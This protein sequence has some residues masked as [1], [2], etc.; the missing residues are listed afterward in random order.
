MFSYLMTAFTTLLFVVL[1]PGILLTIPPNS[2]KI[3]VAVVHG[4]VFSLVYHFTHK[5]VL[6]LTRK[7]EGFQSVCSTEHPDGICPANYSCNAGCCVSKF[8]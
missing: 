7:Y 4:I 3:I 1:T 6:D 5:A 8:R 2:S